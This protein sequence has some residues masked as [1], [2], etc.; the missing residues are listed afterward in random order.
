MTTVRTHWPTIQVPT[1]VKERKTGKKLT[2]MRYHLDLECSEG[3]FAVPRTDFISRNL[4]TG[5][6]THPVHSMW[7]IFT[8]EKGM[9]V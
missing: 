8:L 6:P 5:R 9:S 4:G 3:G 1:L 7:R 2:H